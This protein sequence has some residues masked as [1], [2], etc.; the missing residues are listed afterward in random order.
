MAGENEVDRK[1]I[2][3]S[4]RKLN[5]DGFGSPEA[6]QHKTPLK[7]LSVLVRFWSLGFEFTLRAWC[8]LILDGKLTGRE[9]ERERRGAKIAIFSSMKLSRCLSLHPPQA[10]IGDVV[11]LDFVYCLV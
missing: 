8:T 2:I 3:Y 4:D 6:K 10:W 11:S 1:P 5:W 9:R 7:V